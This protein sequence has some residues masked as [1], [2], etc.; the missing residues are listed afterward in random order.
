MR[1]QMTTNANLAQLIDSNLIFRVTGTSE[2]KED[3]LKGLGAFYADGGRY[4][5]I[6]QR[7]I[8]A[9]LDPI[10]AITEAA[11]YQARSWQ[12]RIG[13]QPNIPK[14]NKPLV[15]KHRLWQITLSSTPSVVE[16]LSTEA[17]KQF[18]GQ[19]LEREI[20]NPSHD[21][22]N[23]QNLANKIRSA[24]KPTRTAGPIAIGIEYPSVRT[25]QSPPAFAFFKTRS[26]W[27]LKRASL[28]MWTLSIEFFDVSGAPITRTNTNRIDWTRF[29]FKL[30]S[31][32]VTASAY[33]QLTHKSGGSGGSTTYKQGHWYPLTIN[34]T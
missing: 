29:K 17:S 6:H 16:L 27:D 4:N 21:Y 22:H 23:L 20:F 25:P 8:Y 12:K 13:G 2:R 24:C 14:P 9:S 19:I 7:T 1:T 5:E 18:R 10:V 34:L 30:D 11:Y 28:E 26:Q 15:S 31:S 32:H 33:K 3:V